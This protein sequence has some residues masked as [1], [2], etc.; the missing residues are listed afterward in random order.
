MTKLFAS[1][2]LFTGTQ[3]NILPRHLT[4]GAPYDVLSS[5]S[6]RDKAIFLT[7]SN[8]IGVWAPF[9]DNYVSLVTGW[10]KYQWC[11]SQ[12]STAQRRSPYS[13]SAGASMTLAPALVARA[14]SASRSSTRT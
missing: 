8:P 6:G 10:A 13:W 3:A 1:A 12:S 7:S 9:G 14:N 5:T 2:E 11:P 4:A